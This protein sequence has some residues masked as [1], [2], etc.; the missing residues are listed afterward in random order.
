MLWIMIL[1]IDIVI[2]QSMDC[3]KNCELKLIKDT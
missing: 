3:I 1:M 2:K